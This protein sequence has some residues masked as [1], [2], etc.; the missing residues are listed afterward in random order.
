MRDRLVG[1]DRLSAWENDRVGILGNGAKVDEDLLV[2]LNEGIEEDLA[3]ADYTV[4]QIGTR[5]WT[6]DTII[7]QVIAGNIDVNPSFQRRNAW[8]DAKRSRFLES[9]ILGVPIPQLVLAEKPGADARG[10]FYVIDGKQ[11]LTTIAGLRDRRYDFWTGRR[12]ARLNELSALNGVLIDDFLADEN[13][14]NLIRQ[15]YNWPIRCTIVSGYTSDDVLYDMFYRLNSGSAP[16][17]G[18]ELRQV[19]YK[20]PFASYLFNVTSE[21]QPIHDVLNTEVPDPRFTDI[22]VLLRSIADEICVEPYA[23]NLKR[24][25][26]RT[27]SVLN[28]TWAEAEPRVVAAY[29]RLNTGI[30]R[31][32]D[33][34]GDY[35]NVGRKAFDGRISGRFNKA[36]FE[37]QAYYFPRIPQDRFTPHALATFATAFVDLCGRREFA[38]AIESTTKSLDRFETRFRLFREAVNGAFDC[39]IVDAP[40]LERPAR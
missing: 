3:G 20:G 10:T 28:E 25:L 13:S 26:D 6:V 5:D 1:G 17:S 29:E 2:D 12:F 39:A 37:V 33:I 40:T 8:N 30:E 24:F 18:Q 4:L 27:M 11:R 32:R 7:Q 23:G 15:M 36:V 16:L 9:L 22:E 21:R 38:T 34:F 19:F 31:G 14:T 35:R